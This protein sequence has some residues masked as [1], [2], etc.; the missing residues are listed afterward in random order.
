MS[1]V[2]NTHGKKKPTTAISK[3]AK[4]FNFKVRLCGTR[5]PETKGSV[6]AK[7]KVVDWIRSYEGEFEDLEELTL[8]IKKINDKMN[9]NINEETRMSPTALFY[10]EKEYLQA[11]PPRIIIDSYLCPNKYKVSNESL[12]R[13]GNS[14]YSVN[15]KLINEEVTVDSFDNNLYI[16]YKGKLVAFHPLN[17]KP[18]NYKPEHYRTLMKG[19]VKETDMDIRITENLNMMDNILES[20]KVEISPIEATK[21]AQALIAFI[22]QHECGRWVINNYAHLSAT[23]QLT[24]IKGM[25]QVLPYVKNKDVFISRIKFSMK[26]NLCKTI[27]FDCFTNDLMAFS[28]A[29]CVLTKE[30]YKII[31][32]KYDKEIKEFVLDL[33]EQWEIPDNNIRTKDE[34]HWDLDEE[35]PFI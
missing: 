20:R 26:Q 27:D 21:S 14:K 25:N 4:D 28:D 19:K 33:K 1:T 17:K 12:I 3:F 16:Y 22:N 30:G 6:E 7:N 18:I 9:I 13:Y 31:G 23:E 5:M 11:L 24:F 8:I 2:A 34:I 35:L 29:D 15:P 32:D 10:K